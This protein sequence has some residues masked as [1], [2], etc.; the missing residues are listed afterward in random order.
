MTEHAWVF[1]EKAIETV[2]DRLMINVNHGQSEGRDV[3]AMIEAMQTSEI[4]GLGD[5]KNEKSRVGQI[6]VQIHRIVL[7]TKWLDR[8]Y[9]PKHREGRDEDIDTE[10]LKPDVTHTTGFSRTGS[11]TSSPIR[12]VDYVS[13]KPGEGPWATFQFFYR[14]AGTYAVKFITKST[15]PDIMY[16][17]LC[18]SDIPGFTNLPAEQLQKF[19]FEGFPSVVKPA[20]TGRSLNARMA[21]LSPMSIRNAL[22]PKPERSRDAMSYEEKIRRKAFNS[23]S[24]EPKPNFGSDYRDASADDE[25]EAEEVYKY[26]AAPL[27]F[28]RPKAPRLGPQRDISIPGLVTL[29]HEG[30]SAVVSKITAALA[31]PTIPDNVDSADQPLIPS[32]TTAF[33]IPKPDS[34]RR[35][36]PYPDLS[37]APKE[38]TPPNF[39]QEQGPS[40]STL[41]KENVAKFDTPF[42]NDYRLSSQ[43]YVHNSDGDDEDEDNP[44]NTE[45]DLET[46]DG[47]DDFEYAVNEEEEEEDAVGL[48]SRLQNV[49]IGK[50]SRATIEDAKDKEE[51]HESRTGATCGAADGEHAQDVD[52]NMLLMAGEKE[53]VRHGK[54]AR[55][56][57]PAD[58]QG[59]GHCPSDP[60]NVKWSGFWT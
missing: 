17:K 3:D 41:S 16:T 27:P 44:P 42:D 24:D 6:V 29:D 32:V 47:D 4:D 10:G 58:G 56:D 5:S 50:R 23:R 37:E 40:P 51:G 11:F 31:G 7:G 30:A 35:P 15:P 43:A 22:P 49:A 1:K 53:E 21:F 26:P 57:D 18:L 25:F 12:V 46:H 2:F 55:T 39:T 59:P 60:K 34:H 13:Y 48:R 45:S 28:L 54:K 52:A 38:S 33:Y 20:R 36:K 19:G 8:D 14:S 9:R